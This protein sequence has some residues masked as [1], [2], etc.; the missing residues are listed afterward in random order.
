MSALASQ[1]PNP[2]HAKLVRE[3]RAAHEAFVA[4]MEADEA[5]PECAQR[6]AER[7]SRRQENLARWWAFAESGGSA[8][9]SLKRAL[10]QI[11]EE[12]DAE[13]SD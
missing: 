3:N 9:D 8:A 11:A 1:T 7:E 5:S 13:G 6:K 10:I 2:D 4:K 12:C